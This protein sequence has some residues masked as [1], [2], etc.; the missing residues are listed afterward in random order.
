M[1]VLLLELMMD[2]M[3]AC[4]QGP[5]SVRR[6]HTGRCVMPSCLSVGTK[7]IDVWGSSSCEACKHIVLKLSKLCSAE[8][9]VVSLRSC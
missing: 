6:S 3:P 5:Q 7:C 9:A 2:T 1:M 8:G 4:T